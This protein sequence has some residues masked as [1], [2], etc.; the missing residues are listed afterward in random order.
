MIGKRE[1]LD[2][3]ARVGLNPSVVEKD[4]ALGWALAGIF[5]HPEIADSWVFKGG[6][7]LKKCFFETYR[8]SEDLDFTLL[9]PAHLDEAFLKRVFGEVSAWIYERTGLEFPADRQDFEMLTNPRGNPSCQ[10]KLSYRGPVSSSSGGLPRVK[11]D[12]TADEHIVLPPVRVPI[13]HPYTDAPEDGITVLSYAYEEAFG[14][15]VRALAE[16]TR[17]RDLYDVV[18]LY[19]NTEARPAATVLMHVLR[20]KCDF[21]GIAVPRAGDLDG[22]RGDL[23]GA[24]GHM[25]GHQLPAL[26]PVDVFWSVLPEFFAWLEGGSAPVIPAAYASASGE[27]LIRER[28]LRLPIG[29]PGQSALEIIRFAAANRL[30]VELHYQGGTRRIEPYSLRQTQDGNVVLHAWNIDRNEHRSYRVDRIEGARSTNQTF[31]PRY[32]VELTPS[33]PVFIPPT[34]HT[35]APPIAAPSFRPARPAAPGRVAQP[36]FGPTYVYQCPYCQK[37]FKRKSMTATLNA[38]KGTNGYACP[39]RSGMYVGTEY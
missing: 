29:L 2:T 6:T 1:I 13:F 18:N 10:G 38:H 36:S 31:T 12:L 19:R 27:I 8:F 25:L 35:A 7:C 24:W 9:D 34:A 33:G 16:R 37:K 14:E 21:K 28:A 39:G 20:Q 4:Y 11:L 32:A 3:A 23:E 26:P 5:A 17:P 15:K 22:H 30:I